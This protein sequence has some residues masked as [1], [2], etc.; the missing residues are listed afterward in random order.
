MASLLHSESRRLYS[1][2]WDSHNSPKNSKW[3]QENLTDMDAKVKAMI[4]LI[5]EDADSF[6]RRA[7]MYYKKRPELMKLVEE[8]Y[9]AYRALAERY[10]HATGEL[11][12]AHKTM[13]E[14]FPNQ[15]H[16]LLADD[17]PCG[18]SSDPEAIPHTPEMPHKHLFRSFL[19]P[20]DLQKDVFG[21]SLIHNTSKNSRRSSEEFDDGVSRKGLKQL[22]EIMKPSELSSENHNLKIDNCSDFD[23]AGKAESE[24]QT[25]RKA[26]AEMLADRDATF[27]QYQNSLEKLSEMEKELNKAEQDAGSLDE[28]AS[29]AEIEIKMLKESLAEL[30]AENAT[31]LVRYDRYLE[32]VASLETM[33]LQAQMDAK[34]HDERAAKAETEAKNLKQELA[35]LEDEK[36]AALVQYKQS[37]EKI[38]LLEAKI[39][40]AE[41]NS[42]ILNEQIDRS[43]ME[44]K[45]L[46]ENL[47]EVNG[48]K[49]T[50]A[51]LY[52]QCLQK[53]SILEV[54]LL[55][56]QEAYERLSREI[57]LGA[58]KLKTAEEHCD[59]LEKSNRSLQLEAD[60]L[61]QKISLKDHELSAKHTELEKLQT[62]MH[63]D[64]SRFLEIESTLQTLQ[65]LYSRSQEEQIS[66]ALELKHGL[67]ILEDLELSKQDFKEEMQ[68]IVEENKTLHVLN[69]SSIRSVKDQQV[70][71]SKLKEIKEKL[72]REFSVKIEESN[73]IQRESHQIKDEILGLNNRYQAILEE[74]ES[75]GLSPKGFAAS[76][77]DLQNENSK[78]KEV[79]KMD[80]D[81]KKALLEKSEDMDKLLRE[82]VFMEFSMSGLNDELDGVR[83]AVKKLQESCQ[84][85]KEEKSVLVS[86]KSAL[87]SQLQ[88]ITESMQKL[89]EKNTLLEKSLFDAKFELEGLRAKSSSLEDFCNLLNNEKHSLINERSILVSQLESVEARL[90]NLERRF[91][92]LEDKFSDAE[93]DR[94]NKI[95]QVEELHVLLSAQKEKH[96]NH[97]LSSE[98]RL[99]NMEN[100]VLQLQEEHRL[101]KKEFEEE[102]DKAVNAEVEMLILQKCV[103]DLEQKNL[104]LLI[105]CQKHV[106]ASTFSDKV[107]SELESENL[108][109]QMELE[110]FVDEI[111]K[112]KMGVQKVFGDLEDGL[113]G[114]HAKR[115]K[116]EEMSI[117][118]ILNNI[119]GMKGTLLKVLEEKQ[120]LLVENF[121]FLNFLSQQQSQGEEIELKKKILEQ[122]VVDTREQ[123][124]I[125]LKDKLELLEMN[126]QLKSVMTKGEE[127][128]N[129]LKSKLEALHVEFLDLQRKF[130]VFQEENS[131]V[132]D[133]NNT[134]VKSVLDLKDAK[135]IAE[136]ENNVILHEALALKTLSLVYESFVINKV[137]EQKELAEHLSNLRLMNS[138]LEQELGLLRKKI[139]VKEA[140]NVYLNESAEKMDKHLLETTNANDH[141]SHQIESLAYHLKKKEA[142]M[143][144]TKGRLKAAEMLNAEF[145]KNVEK[146][147]MEQQVSRLVKENLERHILEL[148]E[149]CMNHKKE[150]E[151]LNEANESFVT[152]MQLLRHEVEQQRAREE[153]LSSELLDKTSEFEIWE[154]EAATF[155]F[156][157]QISSISEALLENKVNDLTG[158]CMKLEDESA[159]KSLAIVQMT[160][161]A[162]VLESEIGELKGELSAY[163]PVIS[164]LKEDFVSLEHTV[165]QTN[166]T[167]SISNQEH[168]DFAVEEN[169]YPSLTENRSALIPDL[170][171]MKER[172]RAIEKLM[173]EE[174][175]TA[176]FNPGNLTIVPEDS[177]VE[178][179]SY[180]EK[181]S[182]RAEKEVIDKSAIDLNLWRTKTENGSLM[183]DIPLDHISDN[184]AS[185]NGRRVNSRTDDQMLELWETAEQDS[186]MKQIYSPTED[187]ITWQ[188]SDNNSSGKFQN[189]SSE[190]EVEKE[191]GVDKLQLSKSIKERTQDGKRRK[192]LERLA[193]DA[194][195]LTSLKMTVL[196]LKKKMETKKPKKMGN[197]AECVETVKRQVEEVEGAVMKL[198]DTNDQ[199]RKEVEESVWSL[200]KDI[201]VELEKSRQIH[202]K[203]VTEQARRVSQQIGRLQFQVQNMQ[204]AL[205]KLADEEKSKGKNRFSGKTVVF[206]RNF[207][208]NGKKSKKKH[209]KGC[210]CGCSR[211]STHED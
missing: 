175:R 56:A 200:K 163:I 65:K 151:K 95:N 88:I 154:A 55:C 147:K 70:E 59:V 197:D 184:P 58:E 101:G 165:L 169:S 47:A 57:E 164:S 102:L 178:V 13:V 46:R 15:A 36:D 93:K 136:D 156:D 135:S 182:G 107:I 68:Q 108:M 17:S 207:I 157:L 131:K 26:L 120:Q 100:L 196:E 84:V 146:L 77:K 66:L 158:V 51:V 128:E 33:L 23:H 133:E 195:K 31:G 12:Q 4:K 86:E 116:Q 79:C 148:S 149:G 174:N 83:D 180:A 99:A 2:W 32:R 19:E 49:E 187:G 94:E 111:R 53:I 201:S 73:A 16:Y 119:E 138:K 34:R 105:E 20:D 9:R 115:I 199:L 166:K 206:L 139:E 198:V 189:T 90:G 172:I 64:N 80:K 27:L 30:K 179:L 14:A 150:I 11:R 153:T 205:L 82:K 113:D 89:L 204:H 71:I 117:S 129:V 134:L 29:K 54:E 21:I 24:V 130:I 60:N 162:S 62:L 140:E 37:L 124:A 170:L 85:L 1:W 44:V 6:A 143:L 193:S 183:K 22:N 78:L 74:L 81:E 202:Q 76:V 109:Q 160:E 176:K 114:G 144:E 192:I 48:E 171:S 18:G 35:I 132:L 118:H 122:E 106:E 52:N 190:L 186:A 209:N 181:Y 98:A 75:V 152:E 42:R 25:L 126:K 10:D 97:K 50:I 121:V 8:F 203:R 125:L 3:L 104:G 92:K 61:V 167:S 127:K 45:A 112:F 155:Y 188:Q 177:N 28:R 43:E 185:K 142:E 110:F 39:T 103:E 210:F 40:L 67:Q 72:E 123:N 38:S 173:A 137:V 87:L 168:K 211:P 96:A 161:R 191:Y 41:E 69:F 5:E 141:L 63:E 145:C 208:H 91:T 159:A 7:E 194:H